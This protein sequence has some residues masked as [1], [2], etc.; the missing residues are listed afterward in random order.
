MMDWE[1]YNEHKAIKMQPGFELYLRKNCEYSRKRFVY[2]IAEKNELVFLD[3]FNF[4]DF[5]CFDVGANIG[6]W[7]MYLSAKLRAKQVHSFEPD[8]VLFSI[9]QKNIV[10]NKAERQVSENQCAIGADKNDIMLYLHPD[11]SGDNRPYFVEGR[12]CIQVQSMTIDTYVKKHRIEKVDFIKMDI[13]GGEAMAIEGALETLFRYQPVLM[14]EFS[15]DVAPYGA[16]ALREKLKSF[17]TKHMQLFAVK[18]NQLVSIDINQ[19][20]HYEG[21]IFISFRDSWLKR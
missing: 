16:A 5:V 7:T 9:L 2:R 6:Y 14:V 12:N 11:N 8:P 3:R 15:T 17:L 19:L 1:Q 18:K 20:Y 4:S 10:L 13:Q 21:N